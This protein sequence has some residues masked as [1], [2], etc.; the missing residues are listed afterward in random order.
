MRSLDRGL[1]YSFWCLDCPGTAPN[2]D[3]DE[4]DFEILLNDALNGTS[5]SDTTAVVVGNYSVPTD[6]ADTANQTSSESIQALTQEL[7]IDDDFGLS[8]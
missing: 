5:E 3:T 8:I 6:D 4:N 1:V 2:V 7:E